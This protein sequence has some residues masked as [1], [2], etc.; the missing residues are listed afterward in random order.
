MLLYLFNIISVC[1]MVGYQKQNW[2]KNEETKI[3]HNYIK[4]LE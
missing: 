1:I 4:N 2:Y 3:L